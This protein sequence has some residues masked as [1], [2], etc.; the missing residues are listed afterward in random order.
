MH[1]VFIGTDILSVSRIESILSSDQK[2]RFLNRIFTKAERAY[3]ENKANPAIHYAGRFSAK[4]AVTKA[5]LSSKL[6][7]EISMKDIEILSEESGAPTVVIHAELPSAYQCKV[8]ISH[9]HD[10]AV[11]FAVLI[12][13][14]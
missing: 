1:D 8:S 14:S 11:A 7:S 12:T 3:C 2:E 9:S 6:L 13:L 4:E 10:S 5:I